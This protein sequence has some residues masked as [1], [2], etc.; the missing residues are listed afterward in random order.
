MAEIDKTTTGL[1]NR[2]IGLNVEGIAILQIKYCAI[3]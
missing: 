3:F 2:E 1:L